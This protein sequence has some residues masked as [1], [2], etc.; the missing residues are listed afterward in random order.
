MRPDIFMGAKS[1]LSTISGIG[2]S[3]REMSA[4]NEIRCEGPRVTALA[5]QGT[6]F[7]SRLRVRSIEVKNKAPSILGWKGLV[8]FLRRRMAFNRNP[9][10]AGSI[11]GVNA[12][13]SE[14]E[15]YR[16][17]KPWPGRRR[18]CSMLRCEGVEVAGVVGMAF[19]LPDGEGVTTGEP[20]TPTLSPG[21]TEKRRYVP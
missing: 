4:S 2:K 15:L 11:F 20:S 6:M 13:P 8:W 12:M 10:S 17:P 3:N 9:S 16:G 7:Y 5:G 21:S 1:T 18:R 19:Q 14:R